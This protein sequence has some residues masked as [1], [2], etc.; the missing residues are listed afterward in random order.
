[1]SWAEFKVLFYN[2]YFPVPEQQRYER[3]YGSICQLD[4]E[5]S[6]DYMQHF[7]RLASFVGPT[8]G[9]TARQARHFKWGLKK[10]ILD[11]I[12]NTDYADV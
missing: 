1:C 9:D 7:M 5:S 4:R 2:R 3:E 11:R 10:W 12:I 8:A 6:S